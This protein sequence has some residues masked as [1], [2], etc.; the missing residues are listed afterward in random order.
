MGGPQGLDLS[1]FMPRPP[2]FPLLVLSAHARLPTGREEAGVVSGAAKTK[3]NVLGGLKQHRQTLSQSWGP[4]G[5]TSKSKVPPGLVLP[6]GPE[7]EVPLQGL[8]ASAGH[9]NSWRP[10]ACGYVITHVTSA[11][12]LFSVSLGFLLVY[13]SL[14]LGLTQNSG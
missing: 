9:C 11:V 2:M 3:H 14:E 5:Q 1:P 4:G 8:L 7:G 10:L 6:G 13:F 12:A